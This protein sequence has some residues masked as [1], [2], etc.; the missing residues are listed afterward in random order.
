MK[1][2][3][4]TRQKE[5]AH[6]LQKMLED[7]GF[8]TFVEPLFTIERLK[9]EKKVFAKAAI[10]TSSNACSAIANSG[11]SSD[12][13]IFTV[14]EKTAKSLQ[15]SGF[16]NVIISPRNSAES[17]CDKLAGETGN[18]LYFHGSIISFD[19][20]KKFSNVKNILAYRTRAV[21]NF[22]PE[23]IRFAQKNIF[24]QVLIFSQN[25]AEIFFALVSKYNLLEY[26]SDSQILC[27]SNKILHKCKS[28]GFKNVADFKA[29]PILKN[30][31]DRKS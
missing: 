1:N 24:D 9:I 25:S 7:N 10:I 11:L 15:Q 18:I 23:L 13:K 16:K 8:V 26:F 31:Y 30:F 2:V 12:I 28:L 22:S 19:F 27:L 20:A 4:I 21:E 5:R 17:L 14:G 3:L 6:D 29:I